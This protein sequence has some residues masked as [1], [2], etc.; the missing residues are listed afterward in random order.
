MYRLEAI[1]DPSCQRDGR[2]RSPDAYGCH[3]WRRRRSNMRLGR[4]RYARLL[5]MLSSYEEEQRRQGSSGGEVQG[6]AERRINHV[7]QAREH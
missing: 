3:S 5:R 2:N 6:A 1:H 7:L 4:L